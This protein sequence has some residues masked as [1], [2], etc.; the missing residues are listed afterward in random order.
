MVLTIDIGTSSAPDI[1]TV[2]V[3][4]KDGILRG[5][6]LG[7]NTGLV[8]NPYQF[9]VDFLTAE[10]IKYDF[11]A[12]NAQEIKYLAKYPATVD[13][14]SVSI[15][16]VTTS[17]THYLVSCPINSFTASTNQKVPINI[18]MLK[19]NFSTSGSYDTKQT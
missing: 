4:P 15:G 14:S 1:K 19:T 18:A 12:K 8:I 5:T 17:N 6:G 11:N 16:P 9:I 2:G 3:T 13:K 7:F 10:Q